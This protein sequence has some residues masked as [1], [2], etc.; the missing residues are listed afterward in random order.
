MNLLSLTLVFLVMHKVEAEGVVV[1]VLPQCLKS[2]TLVFMIY[3]KCFELEKVKLFVDRRQPILPRLLLWS[4][5]S[6]WLRRCLFFSRCCFCLLCWDCFRRCL[7]C[8]NWLIQLG[9]QHFLGEVNS[10]KSLC[11]RASLKY[12]LTISAQVRNGF[13]SKAGVKDSLQWVDQIHQES[14]IS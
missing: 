14:D 2:F 3:Y 10:S 12:D 4:S 7:Y 5:R 11:E 6:S 9:L 8:F 1:P 13:L